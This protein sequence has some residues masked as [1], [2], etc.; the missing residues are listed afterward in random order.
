MNREHV[1]CESVSLYNIL[2]VACSLAEYNGR[3]LRMVILIYEIY[4]WIIIVI[5]LPFM[6]GEENRLARGVS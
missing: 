5:I 3:I 1:G 2:Y 6:C 4:F